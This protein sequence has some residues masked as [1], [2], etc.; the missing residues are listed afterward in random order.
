MPD[1]LPTPETGPNRAQT[2]ATPHGDLAWRQI[3]KVELNRNDVAIYLHGKI[4]PILVPQAEVPQY[5]LVTGLSEHL[6]NRLV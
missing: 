5:T 6:I 3:R 2:I 1:Q 4:V